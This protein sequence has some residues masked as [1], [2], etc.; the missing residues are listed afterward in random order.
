MTADLED[1]R[2]AL[3]PG[4][5]GDGYVGINT[6]NPEDTIDVSGSANIS[7]A[8]T[9]GGNLNV[10]GDISGN[11]TGNAGTV[12]NGI[13]TTSSVT[14]LNDVISV[15]SGKIITDTERTKL[16]GIKTG[17][18]VT[19]ASNV[20]SAGAVMTSEDQ[21]ITGTKT[22]SDDTKIGGALDVSGNITGTLATSAQP[23]IT[24]VG[25][26]LSPDLS[27]TTSIF[28]A[29]DFSYASTDIHTHLDSQLLLRC[30]STGDSCIGFNLHQSIPDAVQSA[31]YCGRGSGSYESNNSTMNFAIVDGI[32]PNND[33]STRGQSIGLNDHNVE[34]NTIMTL[35]G[36]TKRVGIGSTNPSGIRCKWKR[37]Y[38]RQYIFQ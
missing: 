15:G 24:S 8:A 16:S 10:T 6:T 20:K 22:F 33:E 23:N 5:N 9:I 36:T 31:I 21:T 7:G 2:I 19:D 32:N 12:T 18:D 25:T 11:I 37:G 35:Q 4:N 17:A 14:D 27:G 34:Q 38:I 1:D 26:L 13:Y 3:M 29:V 28:K 30:N